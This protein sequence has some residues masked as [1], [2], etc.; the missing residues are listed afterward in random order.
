MLQT[1]YD[2]EVNIAKAEAELAFELQVRI[3]FPLSSTNSISKATN[4][5]PFANTRPL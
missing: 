3:Q 2:Q 1:E 5:L 4:I